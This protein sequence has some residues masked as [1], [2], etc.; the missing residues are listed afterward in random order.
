MIKDT[1][2]Y[3]HKKPNGEVFYVGIGN[4]KRP[5]WKFRDNPYWINIV[6]KYPDYI[7]EVL[8]E[9]LDWKIACELET[10]LIS[11]Y[12]RKIDG[13]NLCNMTL[14]GDGTKGYKHSD[15]T[16]QR[17]KELSTGNKNCVGF[18]HSE[19]AK[20]NMSL[21]HLGNVITEETKLKMSL[22]Q[23]GRAT[24]LSDKLNVLKAHEKLRGRIQQEDEKLKRAN[25]LKKPIEV[26]GVLYNS[27]EDYCKENKKSRTFVWRKLKD[28]MNKNYNYIKK[29]EICQQ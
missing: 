10:K 9:N 4:I 25:S 19:E 15:E 2:V 7:I 6:K 20:K 5:F 27:I 13:G 11:K 12:K 16:K 21:A 17:L 23:K 8:Q 29:Q 28:S 26:F 24:R 18:K 3:L 1:C 22:K 14:G